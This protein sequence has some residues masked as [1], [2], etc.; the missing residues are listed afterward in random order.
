[1]E[2]EICLSCT[3]PLQPVP[4]GQARTQVHC[5]RCGTS[6]WGVPVGS[7]VREKCPKCGEP[8]PIHGYNAERALPVCRACGE[9]LPPLKGGPPTPWIPKA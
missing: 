3:E 2:V 6:V 8:Q 1:M 9:L 4:A 5:K 7:S